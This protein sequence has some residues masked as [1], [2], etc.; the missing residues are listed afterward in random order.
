MLEALVGAIS[1][2]IMLFFAVILFMLSFF[3][4]DSILDYRIS[5]KLGRWFDR[6]FGDENERTN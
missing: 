6:K 3:V 2:M 4:A 5:K 1:F